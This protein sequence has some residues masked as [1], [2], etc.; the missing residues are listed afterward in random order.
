MLQLGDG[1]VYAGKAAIAAYWRA[2]FSARPDL[3][4]EVEEVAGFGNRCVLRWRA[5][6]TSASSAQ[7]WPDW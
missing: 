3:Q 2:L 4:I 6:W 1:A 7:R 5:A